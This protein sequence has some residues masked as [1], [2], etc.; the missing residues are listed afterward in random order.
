MIYLKTPSQ[1]REL[2]YVN[3][4][5]ME[6]LETCYNYIKP[7]VYT[8]ELE[9]F[10]RVFCET[11]KVKASFYGYKGFPHLLCVSVNNEIVH[12]FPG[13][14]VIFEGDIVSV[15][16]GLECNGYISDAAF[17]KAVG[18]VSRNTYKLV[19]VTEEC[20][21]RGISKAK[22]GN[23]LFDISKAIFNWAVRNGFDVV[24]DYV[25]HGVG[26]KLHEEPQV[27]NY[28]SLGVN[29]KLKAGM[30]LAIEPMLVE[31]TY[32]SITALNGWTVLTADGG[33]SAH[34]E[35]SIVITDNGPK[36]LGE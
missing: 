4:L 35:R 34:F 18:E 13:E 5:G 12:G 33:K 19:K 31:G 9:D 24:R 10:A 36:I 16:F 8:S 7:G 30:V 14:R 15:D 6:F 26:F 21:E 22:D 1:L 2:E 28:V 3:K 23:R 17:T 20:L 29:Y 11:Y 27:P 32:E 25:G